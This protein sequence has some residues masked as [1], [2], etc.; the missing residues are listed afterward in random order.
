MHVSGQAHLSAL[1]GHRDRVRIGKPRP[2]QCA[3]DVVADVCGVDLWLDR[4]LIGDTD[5][6]LQAAYVLLGR[7]PLEVP[8]DDTGQRDPALID[9]YL[10]KI[11][12]DGDIPG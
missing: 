3:A 5:D 6:A 11:G 4:D 2:V 1:C 10:D 9:R 7:L 8:F 12:W